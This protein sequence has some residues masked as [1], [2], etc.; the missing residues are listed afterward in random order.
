MAL[1]KRN[2][3]LYYYRSIRNGERVRK[4]YP[5]ASEFARLV[6]EG[7]VLRRTGREAQRQRER[8]ELERLEVLAAPV[9]R[10][11]RRSRFSLGR[12]SWR[13]ATGE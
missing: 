7:D 3:N 5:G 1:E 13:L 10:W 6:A 12:I 9:L 4:V 2:G 8:A 11:A